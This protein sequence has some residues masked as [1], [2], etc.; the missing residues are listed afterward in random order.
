M[1][2]LRRPGEHPALR[3]R[4]APQERAGDLVETGVWRGGASIFMRAV[5]KAYGDTTRRVRLADSF[6]GLPKPDGRYAQDAED[7]HWESNEVL[8]VSVEQVRAN[9]ARYAPHDQ[10]R[11]LAGRSRHHAHHPIERIAVL[12]VDGDM[13]SSTMD[14]LGSL[15]QKVSPGGFVI[16]DDYGSTPACR[17]AVDEFR[18][19]GTITEPLQPIDWAGVFWR[20]S[21]DSSE[22]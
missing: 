22:D 13:Y 20:R 10:G 12:R 15:Y 3:D 8:G 11:F 19:R 5:L 7:R 17:Q 18:A 16:V 4:G 14:A 6:E 2:G 9:F 21:A 1:I